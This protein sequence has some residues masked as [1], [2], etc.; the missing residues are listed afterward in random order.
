MF[1]FWTSWNIWAIRLLRHHRRHSILNS[2]DALSQGS[3]CIQLI[4]IIIE[5]SW[6]RKIPDKIIILIITFKILFLKVLLFW[7][8][9]KNVF[10]FFFILFRFQEILKFLRIIFI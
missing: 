8:F 5:I 2:Y 6:F 7:E 3:V 10:F 1:P 9:I 4:P